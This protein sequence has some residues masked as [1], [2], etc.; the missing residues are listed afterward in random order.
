MYVLRRTLPQ[1]ELGVAVHNALDTECAG[2]LLKVDIIWEKRM[3]Y[4]EH[5]PFDFGE[6]LR[7]QAE[8]AFR[9]H[10]RYFTA[11][12]FGCLDP[13]QEKCID[14]WVRCGGAAWWREHHPI[15]V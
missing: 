1:G 11:E 2:D 4:D 13:D 9:P 8:E 10:N 14:H 5:P 3:F 7:Q 12:E 15:P 6:D